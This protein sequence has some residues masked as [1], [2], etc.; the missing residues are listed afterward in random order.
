M[1]TET[2]RRPAGS[3]GGNIMRTTEPNHRRFAQVN[4]HPRTKAF[5]TPPPASKLARCSF[6][7]AAKRRP[8]LRPTDEGWH[9]LPKKPARLDPENNPIHAF[10]EELRSIRFE[11]G[12]PTL[13]VIAQQIPCSHPTVSAY[14]NGLRLP[15][16]AQLKAFLRACNASVRSKEMLKKLAEARKKDAESES[17]PDVSTAR[18][19]QSVNQVPDD[20]REVLREETDEQNPGRAK[21]P[22]TPELPTGPEAPEIQRP[23]TPPAHQSGSLTAPPAPDG[24]SDSGWLMPLNPP[25]YTSLNSIPES[26]TRKRSRFSSVPERVESLESPYPPESVSGEES[27]ANSLLNEMRC[28]SCNQTF[29]RSQAASIAGRLRC[30]RCDTFIN[31]QGG[32]SIG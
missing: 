7:F 20:M 10:A 5:Q 24:T 14:L 13:Q 2:I 12:D 26:K 29:R 16:V 31:D 15:P 32:P 8:W 6:L 3:S 1:T 11:A 27:S 30:P 22:I 18:V 21:S 17:Q 9:P 23:S 28:F 4:G 25:R 19:Q